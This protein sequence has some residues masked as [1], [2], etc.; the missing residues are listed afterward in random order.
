[1]A[2]APGSHDAIGRLRA[3]GINLA[4]DD[5]GTG[6]SS[7]A[8]LKSLPVQEIKIDQSFVRDLA[9]NV[10]DAAIVRST[11]DLG[12]HLGLRV[13]AEGVIDANSLWM[14]ERYGCD[15]AQGNHISE[16]LTGDE[17]VRWL[18]DPASSPRAGRAG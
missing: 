2:M 17:I 18:A 3:L 9:N 5:F 13:V 1:M 10:D 8:H 4:I 15:G 12:H 16:P 7:L 6:Y 11:I 14:L